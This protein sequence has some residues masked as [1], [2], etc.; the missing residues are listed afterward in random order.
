MTRSP[1]L[2]MPAKIKLHSSVPMT[3]VLEKHS[4]QQ[5]QRFQLMYVACIF[6]VMKLSM[7]ISFSS[8]ISQKPP[9]LDCSHKSLR[10][11]NIVSHILDTSFFYE[12]LS[13]IH[14]FPNF[15]DHHNTVITSN[16]PK[17]TSLRFH[18]FSRNEH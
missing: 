9:Y 14:N 11:D 12:P 1:T 15:A 7:T 4:V 18:V 16:R 3:S 10:H 8:L 6:K 5:L 2:P 17:M 13:F